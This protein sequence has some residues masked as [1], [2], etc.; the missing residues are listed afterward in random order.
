MR[1]WLLD[2]AAEPG[3]KIDL[4]LKAEDGSTWIHRSHY[5]QN[6]YLV[7]DVERAA[8]F[9]KLE[10]IRFERCSRRFRGRLVE[11]LRVYAECDDLEEYA[12][13]LVKRVG[14][15]EVYEAD[16]RSSAKYLLEKGL[17]PCSWLEVEGELAGEED[18]V[19]ILEGG[20]AR[21]AADAPPPRLRIAALDFVFFAEKGSARPDRDPIRLISISFDDG[22][23]LQLEGDER[24][25]LQSLISVIK[26]RDP[27]IL[28][29][30]GLNRIQWGYLLERARKLG[31]KPSLGRLGAEPRTSIHGHVSIRGRLNIDLEE[32][33]RE[34]PELTI[35]NLE[36]FVE[37]LGLKVELDTIEEYELA[38]R[39]A[40]DKESVKRYSMQRA[41]AI[42]KAFEALRDFVFN[43][44]AL[45]YM[46]ADY[47][48][49]ASAGFRVENYLMSLA[50]RS[51]ELIPRRTEVIH[52]SYPGGLVKEPIKGLH[53]DVAV[54]DF[55]SMY[56]S[57]MIK[58]NISFDTLS[59][60]GEYVAPNGY[61]FRAEPEGFLP[62]AL[63]TLLEERRKIQDLLKR[64]PPDSVEARILDARQRVVKIIA[65]AIYGYTGWTG[66]RWYSREVAEA[67]TAWGREGISSTIRKAE[68]LGMKVV[69]SD[70]DSVFLKNYEGKLEKLV[71]WIEK[72]LGLEAKLEKVFRRVVFTEAK[73][74]Y[75][76][77]TEDD[78]IEIV[79]LEAVRGDWSWIAREAQ[80]ATIEALLR[81]GDPGEALRKAK[82]YVR[83][84]KRGEVDLKKLII[85]RQITRPLSEYSATQPHIIVARELV[86]EGW[87]IQ[88]G[89]KVG[90]IIAKGSGPLYSRARPYFKIS[91]DEV[92][93]SYY[94][95]KQVV[96]ACGRILEAVGIKADKILETGEST[97]MEFF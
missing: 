78:R 57:L 4:W 93:W 90:Y 83:M 86:K 81:T 61:R 39:W 13:R 40:R 51:G 20:E 41:R 48:L 26:E 77:I 63:K 80:K 67:T 87:R 32:M 84:L 22:F 31:I 55:R 12:S 37:Y 70:T 3:S 96:P 25:I 73:K 91:R 44:S 27:D 88:P 89:D 69:Y 94:I 76:G 9:L 19:R 14:N 85:W 34:I 30:F 56:P 71:E 82:D 18:G 75:A 64:L 43:L 2:I 29:G 38:E 59:P 74:R 45:T 66:A 42:L 49:T 35:E 28:V 68:D 8:S 53:E 33:A 17:R 23:E 16:I 60:D 97:L 52:V 15:V 54:L 47:V 1:L 58:Y 50:I 10:N 72:D 65:N 24:D 5:T 6:F 79:G 7:G 95:E 92:D 36:E 11:A 46:P 62:K 21:E